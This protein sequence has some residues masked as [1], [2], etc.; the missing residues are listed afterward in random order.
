MVAGEKVLPAGLEELALAVKEKPEFR[1]LEPVEKENP[2]LEF[3]ALAV[4]EKNAEFVLDKP[5]PE[6][7]ENPELEPVEEIELK[8]K[9]EDEPNGFALWFVVPNCTCPNPGED[10]PFD[11]NAEDDVVPKADKVELLIPGVADEAKEPDGLV[12]L[13]DRNELLL[14][15]WAGTPDK[16]PPVTPEFVLDFSELQWA[17]VTLVLLIWAEE[18][19]SNTLVLVGN[20]EDDVKPEPLLDTPEKI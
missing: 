16:D 17:A 8:E 13:C 7:D 4:E 10:E 15:D 14:L 12:K 1:L 18:L 5:V 11:P 2:E 3:D 20:E 19:E 9:P 6:E